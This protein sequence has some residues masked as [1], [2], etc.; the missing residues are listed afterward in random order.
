MWV[1]VCATKGA[2]KSAMLTL[3]TALRQRKVHPGPH[4]N[5]KLGV[6]QVLVGLGGGIGRHASSRATRAAHG[7][8]GFAIGSQL[9]RNSARGRSERGFRQSMLRGCEAF[10]SDAYA[11]VTDSCA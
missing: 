3:A 5:D 10:V 1:E 11:V 4:G 8:R 7:R 2:I 6:G 9:L